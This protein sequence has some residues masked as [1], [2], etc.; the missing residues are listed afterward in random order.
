MEIGKT[1]EAFRFGTLQECRSVI[2]A[3]EK[4]G[5]SYDEFS[6][7]LDEEAERT[8]DAR[9]PPPMPKIP[10]P[11]RRQLRRRCPECGAWMRVFTVNDKP[12]NMVGGGWR[13]QW[14]CT[15]RKCY[16]DEYS[17]KSAR[18]EAEPYIVE[19]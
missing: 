3:L 9:T 4:N 11:P 16:W 18:E 5:I 12:G 10:Y 17:T 1:L 15:N 6:N 7:W 13:S 19:E 2:R 8:K 14:L